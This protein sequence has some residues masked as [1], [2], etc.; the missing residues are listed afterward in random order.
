MG[1]DKQT[2]QLFGAAQVNVGGVNIG[3]VDEE[4]VKAPLTSTI[5]EA[6]SGKHGQT[7]M[8]K[9]LNGQRLIVEFNLIQ[10][11][12]M[13]LED[14]LPGATRV[15]DGGN[16]KLT[17]GLIGGTEIPGVQLI[18][19]PVIPGQTPLF[20][21]TLASA[22]PIGDFDL[23][24]SGGAYQK[25]ACKFEGLVDEA[26]G[27]DGS[28]L[29]QFGDASITQ[30]AVLPTVITVVPAN[31][32][33]AIA[34]GTNV[35]WTMS[36]DLDGNTVN[37]DSVHLIEDPTGAATEVAASVSL[38]NAGAGTTITLTPDADLTAATKY[39]AMLEGSIKDKAGNNL[40]FYAT[41]F[42]TA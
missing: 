2:I 12:F 40:V 21:L 41:D 33:P 15:S 20:N 24:Y 7:P 42:D 22:A 11:E 25:W 14:V 27:N 38:V 29:A 31:N 6:L 39:L 32:A 5:I 18:L 13:N 35:V 23:L 16:D 36:E 4:G 28:F 30:D 8:K 17:F 34:I 9:W 26:G 3:H 19:T 10:T 37:G 1:F